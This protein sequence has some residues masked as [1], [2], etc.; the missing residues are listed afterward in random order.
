[1]IPMHRVFRTILFAF[2]L[3]FAVSATTAEGVAAGDTILFGAYEQDNDPDNGHELIEWIVLEVD[4][5]NHRLWVVSRYG[6]DAQP[7]NAEAAEVTWQTC[8]LREWLNGTFFDTAFTPEEQVAV[9]TV[10]IVCVRPALCLDAS[11]L[12]ES[13]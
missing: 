2:A 8:T 10:G 12:P 4:E 11:A 7:Y 13:E 9:L 5:A 6:L 3:L 1:M